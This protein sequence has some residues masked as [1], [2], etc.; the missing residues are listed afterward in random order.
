MNQELMTQVVYVLKQITD[1]L[2]QENVSPA[3]KS[4]YLV[5][6]Y[7]EQAIAEMDEQE[8]QIELR[9]RL[10]EALSAMEEEDN[11]LLADI[12][13]YEIVRILEEYIEE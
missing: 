2:Y 4:L 11:I 1:M 8:R 13:Q 5:L 6:P 9:E 7:M 10:E 3:Y 12:I